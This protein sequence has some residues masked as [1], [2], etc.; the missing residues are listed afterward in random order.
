MWAAVLSTDLALAPPDPDLA[1]WDSW[2]TRLEVLDKESE[3]LYCLSPKYSNSLWTF[4]LF[5]DVLLLPADITSELVT[6]GRPIVKFNQI[7]RKLLS[8]SWL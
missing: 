4:H 8:G 6:W 1:P 5:R 7:L 3:P 2:L